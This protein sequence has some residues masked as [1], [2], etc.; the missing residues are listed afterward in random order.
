MPDN[1]D[2]G[3][4][5]YD[6]ASDNQDNTGHD[7]TE[8]EKNGVKKGSPYVGGDV[9]DNPDV[10]AAPAIV[11]SGEADIKVNQ[12][13]L[14]AWAGQFRTWSQDLQTAELSLSFIDTIG[15]FK[16]GCFTEASTLGGNL[17]KAV[18][19]YR[20]NFKTFAQVAQALASGL[21]AAASNFAEGEKF[22]LDSNAQFR[23]AISRLSALESTL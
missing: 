4:G 3:D 17:T 11:Y 18:S 6:G 13:N 10:I 7:I 20:A 9:H 19:A 21:D 22:N 23:D 16:P 5:G 2:G 8:D 1:G 14:Q 15:Y 12:A